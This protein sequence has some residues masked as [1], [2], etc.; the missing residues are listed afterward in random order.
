MKFFGVFSTVGLYISLLI[1]GISF[2]WPFLL[3]NDKSLELN[4]V[5]VVVVCLSFYFLAMPSYKTKP[6]LIRVIYIL[7]TIAVL[8][9]SLSFLTDLI[10]RT[11]RPPTLAKDDWSGLFIV[12]TTL[13]AGIIWGGIFDWRKNKAVK[14]QAGNE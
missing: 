11:S 6:V 5:G 7:A 13:I 12:P 4:L 2:S 10:R 9:F 1:L 8:N 14:S 3:L